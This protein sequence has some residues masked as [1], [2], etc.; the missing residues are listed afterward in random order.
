MEIVGCSFTSQSFQ[1]SYLTLRYELVR[2]NHSFE[3]VLPNS[4]QLFFLQ[5]SS[6]RDP[7]FRSV[8]WR[9]TDTPWGMMLSAAFRCQFFGVEL[10][11]AFVSSCLEAGQR[12]KGR[13]KGFKIIYR[14]LRSN[15]APKWD[16]CLIVRPL[17]AAF[18]VSWKDKIS[19]CI[20]IAFPSKI[21]ACTLL[22]CR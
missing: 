5:F 4:F 3:R 13:F 18:L 21:D 19:A 20:I 14:L 10:Y 2:L 22:V 8:N 9:Q 12:E 1:P 11:K 15:T 16:H 17:S 7:L 6:Q